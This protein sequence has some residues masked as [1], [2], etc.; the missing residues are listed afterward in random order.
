MRRSRLPIAV[1]V[2]AL[3]DTRVSQDLRWGH[4][5]PMSESYEAFVAAGGR[6]LV[7]PHCAHAAWRPHTCARARIASDDEVTQLFLAADKVIDYD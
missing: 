4:G 6:V 5:S 2:T 7:C 3:A 1:L